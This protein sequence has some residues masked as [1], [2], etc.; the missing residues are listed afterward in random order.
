MTNSAQPFKWL[1]VTEACEYL[2]VSKTT[3]YT[4]MQEGRLPFYYL[5]GSRTRRLKLS[6]LDA[7]LELGNAN[8]P[9]DSVH[10]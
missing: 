7:L 9:P 10:N 3:L 4:Y 5:A 6:D 2:S 8:D 1:S